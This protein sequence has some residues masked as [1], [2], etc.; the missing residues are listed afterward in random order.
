M[1]RFDSQYK[2]YSPQSPPFVALIRV[3]EQVIAEVSLLVRPPAYDDHLIR[4]ANRS[5]EESGSH[6]YTW[7]RRHIASV[8]GRGEIGMY[9]YH[10]VLLL[11][12]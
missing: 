7:E 8:S 3:A 5:V 4:K 1:R 2:L 12:I 6:F 10:I 11:N 9:L